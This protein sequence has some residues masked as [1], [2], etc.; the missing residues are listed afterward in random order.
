[1]IEPERSSVSARSS[2][3]HHVPAA[4]RARSDVVVNNS[5]ILT[6]GE[7]VVLT[8]GSIFKE[9]PATGNP[10]P[11]ANWVSRAWSGNHADL[12]GYLAAGGFRGV[13]HGRV[14]VQ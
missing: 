10:D 2:L 11:L 8:P 1:M 4:E 13:H 9:L 6:P 12:D 3:S 7:S 5:L 14:A